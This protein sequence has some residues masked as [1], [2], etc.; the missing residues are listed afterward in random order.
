MKVPYVTG[1][2]ERRRNPIL[3]RVVRLG[4][5]RSRFA[6]RRTFL[7]QPLAHVEDARFQLWEGP[8]AL[9]GTAAGIVSNYV[10]AGALACGSPHPDVT[11]SAAV[12]SRRTASRCSSVSATVSDIISCPPY[13]P[14]SMAVFR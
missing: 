14:D 4:E 8:S 3:Y 5:R 9:A 1:K 13:S 10:A 7:F 2:C 12:N 11:V 6:A